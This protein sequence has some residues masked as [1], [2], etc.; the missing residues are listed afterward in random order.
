LFLVPIINEEARYE[1]G[2]RGRFE[3]ILMSIMDGFTLMPY[4]I[5]I[6]N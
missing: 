5:R 2:A 3:A 4:N 1:M 6:G